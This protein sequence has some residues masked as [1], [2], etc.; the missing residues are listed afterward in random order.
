M[1]IELIFLDSIGMEIAKSDQMHKELVKEV[2]KRRKLQAENIK[3][4]KARR[5][6]NEFLGDIIDDYDK[7]HAFILSEK[8]RKE[9]AFRHIIEYLDKIMVEG[10][11]TESGLRETKME[12]DDLLGK[13]K[14]VRT[15][16]DELMKITAAT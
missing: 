12:Q 7:Y 11:L 9:R 2:C 14:N 10:K 15:E 3:R 13:I 6:T 5:G 8:Q 1:K 16:M 4:L